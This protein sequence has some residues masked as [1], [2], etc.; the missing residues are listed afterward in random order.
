MKQLPAESSN[1]SSIEVSTAPEG[2]PVAVAEA[3]AEASSAPGK[4]A[5][6]GGA[7]EDA[8]GGSEDVPLEESCMMRAFSSK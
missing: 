6:E 8:A 2:A 4:V 5:A 3:S 1:Q 7:N